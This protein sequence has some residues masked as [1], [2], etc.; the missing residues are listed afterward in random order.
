MR[1][2]QDSTGIVDRRAVISDLHRVFVEKLKPSGYD[3]RRLVSHSAD[4]RKIIRPYDRLL[5]HIQTAHGDRD[6][7]MEHGPGRFRIFHNIELRRRLPVSVRNAAAH[8]RD[9]ANLLLYLRMDHQKLSHIGQRPCRKDDDRLLA[10]EDHLCH[11]VHSRHIL[12]RINRLR[13]GRAVQSAVAVPVSC[14]HRICGDRLHGSPDLR[15]VDPKKSTDPAH[16]IGSLFDGLVS[17]DR[18]DQTD[19]QS[20]ICLGKN[21]GDGI[22]MSRIPVK[23]DRN[24]THKITL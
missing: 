3:L 9:P 1:H 20:G 7:G 5:G 8:Q 2:C 17:C 4:P 6:P 19:I 14:R 15:R 21:P 23:N 11:Q 13:H 12:Q 24:F 18:R 16:I 10:L 22:V